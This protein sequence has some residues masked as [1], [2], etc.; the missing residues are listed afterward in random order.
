MSLTMHYACCSL[1]FIPLVLVPSDFEYM[2]DRECECIL[3]K[4]LYSTTKW[5]I[6]P[7]SILTSKSILPWLTCLNVNLQVQ[8]WGQ[9]TSF[10]LYIQ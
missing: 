9:K 8:I 4:K 10:A 5:C 3:E 1:H 2:W 6:I 7:L